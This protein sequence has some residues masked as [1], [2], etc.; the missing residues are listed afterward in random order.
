MRCN[1]KM[2]LCI[3]CLLRNIIDIIN[4]VDKRIL[5]GHNVRVYNVR[6]IADKHKFI[7]ILSNLFLFLFSVKTLYSRQ[8]KTCEANVL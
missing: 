6:M 2:L 8:Q 4:T 7:Q 3:P 5:F 1:N